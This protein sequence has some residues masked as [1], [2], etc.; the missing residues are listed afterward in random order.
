[1][2]PRK[3]LTVRQRRLGSELRRLREH[4]GLTLAQAAERLGADRTTISNTES[5]RFGVSPQRVRAWADHYKCPE[6]AYVDALAAMAAE[7]VSGWWEHY[8]G[9]LAND[10]LDLAELEYHAA[11]VR[12]VQVMYMPGLL[13]TEEYARSVFAESVPVPSPTRQRRLLAHRLQRRDVL[14]RPNPP[15]CTFLIHE[16]ALRMA[17][18]SREVA[19]AQLVHLLQ[20]SDRGNITIRVI[21]FAAGGF[22]FAS[23]SAHYVYGIVPQLD[24]VQVDTATGS[25]FLDA[26]TSLVNWRVALDR[27]EERSLDPGR[28]R[29]FIRGIVQSMKV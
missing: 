21:P 12:S 23:S 20:E 16:A 10:A 6:P 15:T 7:R 25:S 18:G 29:D 13:Q 4:A 2:P 14:D 26:E 1:M 3:L 17:Y 27:T 11:A 22:P 24:T 8:R 9:E 28:S 19:R 5:G